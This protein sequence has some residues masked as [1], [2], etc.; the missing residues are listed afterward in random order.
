MMLSMPLF[1][2]PLIKTLM[3]CAFSTKISNITQLNYPQKT[4]Q[5]LLAEDEIKRWF[6]RRLFVVCLTIRRLQLLWI[7]VKLLLAVLGINYLIKRSN[8]SCQ[9][10]L[11]SK[12]L[13]LISAM[14]INQGVLKLLKSYLWIIID[15]YYF[16]NIKLI[17][18]NWVY[19]ELLFADWVI[20]G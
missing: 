5:N 13:S 2:A 16:K 20:L 11:I 8:F 9:I 17:A 1:I 19:L 6:K 4:H 15:S 18:K 10:E 12:I 14:D 7:V 3:A